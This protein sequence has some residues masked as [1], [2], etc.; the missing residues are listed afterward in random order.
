[1]PE[2]RVA[3]H[4]GQRRAAECNLGRLW[5]TGWQWRDRSDV[6]NTVWKTNRLLVTS[7]KDWRLKCCPLE[8]GY[9]VKDDWANSVRQLLSQILIPL[10]A[11]S[12]FAA[13]SKTNSCFVFFL[14]SDSLM[15]HNKKTWK[16]APS[17][18]RKS[19]SPQTLSIP[20]YN[21][22]NSLKGY[23][24]TLCVFQG[25]YAYVHWCTYPERWISQRSHEQSGWH[26]LTSSSLSASLSSRSTSA[27]F[28]LAMC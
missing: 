13:G 25:C 28:P 4:R 6:C 22:R 12:V 11:V 24:I 1:M 26:I 18:K 7:Y 21:N 14:L 20:F 27:S 8:A 16:W 10:C 5:K 9:N 23:M 17:R 19:D 3:H 15:W 2:I